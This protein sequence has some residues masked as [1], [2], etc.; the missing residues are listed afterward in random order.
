MPTSASTARTSAPRPASCRCCSCSAPTPKRSPPT[1]GPARGGGG[2]PPT[3]AHHSPTSRP[4][5]TSLPVLHLQRADAEALAADARARGWGE[6]AAR[7]RRLIERLHLLI[8]PADA[9]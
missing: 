4:E 2:R 1:P 8:T 6:E 5:P 9:S 3:T 7:H